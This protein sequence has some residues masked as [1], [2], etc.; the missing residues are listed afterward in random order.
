MTS[1]L[2]HPT[3]IRNPRA[4]RDEQT[5]SSPVVSEG[6]QSEIPEYQHS[7][8]HGDTARERRLAGYR[9]RGAQAANLAAGTR[10]TPLRRR[11]GAARGAA[12]PAALAVKD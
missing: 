2:A 1:L 8:K 10:M 7:R 9:S 5:P 11:S 3:G 12:A 4:P 6:F